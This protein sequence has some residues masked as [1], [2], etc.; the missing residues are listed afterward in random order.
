[1]DDATQQLI[2]SLL[3]EDEAF[4]QTKQNNKTDPN[5]H[6][7]AHQP[8]M[9]TQKEEETLSPGIHRKKLQKA[10]MPAANVKT[11][12]RSKKNKSRACNLL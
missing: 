12:T 4:G 3:D 1:M 8:S 5:M 2:N 9:S 6:D 7:A 10:P 11:E